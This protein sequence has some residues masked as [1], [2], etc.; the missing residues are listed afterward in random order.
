MAARDRTTQTPL[1]AP[2]RDD[3]GDAGRARSAA[4]AT[5]HLRTLLDD[6]TFRA[7]GGCPTGSTDAIL[8]MSAA[9][10]YTACPNPFMAGCLEA[11]G[12]PYDPEEPYERKPFAV[13]V[14][15]GK[16]DALY[17]AH[18]Y[19]TKVPHLAIVPSI[20]HYT[21]PGDI[22][23]DGFCGS[24]MTGVAAQ[25]C[26]TAPDDYRR[27]LE[28][29]WGQDGRD[30]PTWG[31]RRAILNDLSP[32]ATFIAA[33]YNRPFDVN[34]FATA[35]REIL[36]EVE[37]ELGWM[38]ETRHTDGRI[39]RIEYTVWSEMFS[40][41]DCGIDITF[42][43]EALDTETKRVRDDF[44][45][46]SCGTRL[47]KDRLERVMETSTDP[48]TGQPWKRVR[49]RPVMINY[50]VGAAKFEKPLDELDLAVLDRIQGI[51]FP[52]TV[53]TNRFPIETM[54]HG[55]RIA[56]KARGSPT[57]ITSSSPGPLT[58]WLPSGAAPTPTPTSAYARCCCSPSSRQFGACR[59]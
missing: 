40:C 19:H 51:P 25:W 54:S 3:A 10:E 4:E 33:N 31:A 50:R 44:P 23:L 47:T 42:T 5:A 46:P 29:E 58:P 32:A 35:T 18:G 20:L 21:E 56:P 45:C 7:E 26:G 34:A 16:T 37:R 55:S 12:R 38:Y 49:F 17:R 48:A 59:F 52:T 11:N 28:S 1:V 9:P 30:A 14:S 43:D 15:V 36:D 13:D 24:G 53:P 8:A 27:T 57:S 22:V 39:G 6:P 2:V 41:P